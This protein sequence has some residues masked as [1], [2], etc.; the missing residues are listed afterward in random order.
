MAR[1]RTLTL[2]GIL[3]LAFLAQLAGHLLLRQY[4]PNA[5]VGGVG[6]LLVAVIFSYVLLIRHDI[7]GFILV[8]YVCSHFSYADDHGG[9][10][11]LITFVILVSYLAI[12]RS[13]QEFP[14]R[15]NVMLSLLGVFILWN[16]LGWAMKNP[17]PILPMFKGI[18]V[19]FGFILMFHL[20]SNVVITKE[21]FRLF[22]A[23]TLFMVLY[24]FVVALNQRYDLV[25][26]NTPLIG[27]YSDIGNYIDRAEKNAP[28]TGT[29][30]HFE[31]F[32]EYGVLLI[33]LLVPLL[34]S[35]LTQ[36]E[37]RF[38]I[39]RIVV[40]IF[41]CLSFSMLTSNRA[42]AILSILVITFYYLVL[43]M[44]IF[45]SIDRFG[46]QI[47][48]IA[49]VALLIPVVG[50]YVGLGQLEEDFA[51]M[52][53][54]K[55]SAESIVSG[56]SINRGGLVSLGLQRINSD[57]WWI[58]NGYGVQRS[59]LWA[60]FG[61]DPGIRKVGIA[62]FH[63]L[64]LS[65]PMI[66]GW[67][68]SLAFLSMIVITAFRLFGVSLRYRNRKSFLIVLAVGFTMFWGIFLIDQYK[69][70]ILRNPNY[71][72]LFWIWLGLA[73]SVFKTILYEKRAISEPNL[74]SNLDRKKGA[75]K[76]KDAK[77]WRP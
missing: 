39:N 33:A 40:M 67:I 41:V 2:T 25:N 26:W 54:E 49:V 72:M 68:G 56:E 57:S 11:N 64:Y 23:V 74:S 48:L 62:D 35:S 69:I 38:G 16:L 9:L 13:T 20:A 28:T 19:F 51:T 6:F 44:R 43:P 42:A 70:S 14:Q 5:A 71:Q 45:S 46:R 24:Q 66:Y 21:R 73:N 4:M 32:G 3:V 22:L 17:I 65:L 77:G 55:F 63:S 60:W 7:F 10:F 61:A 50:V 53:K 8:V 59:N 15:D 12:N 58:G 34:S 29:L 47:R 31:L 27:G 37:L 30:R 18:A 52:A 36:R 1:N 75:I 76:M